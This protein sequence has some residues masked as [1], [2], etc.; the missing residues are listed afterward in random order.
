MPQPNLIRL[1]CTVCKRYNYW[2]RKN[3]RTVERML[4]M[5]PTDLS[6]EQFYTYE[7]RFKGPF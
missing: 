2:T 6:E 4:G 7:Q 1:Q 3:I 5:A